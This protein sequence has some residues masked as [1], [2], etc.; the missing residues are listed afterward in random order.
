LISKL[1]WNVVGGLHYLKTEDQKPY[2]E[3][4]IGLENIGF[5]KLKFLRV[6]YVQSH[7]NG[8]QNNGILLGIDF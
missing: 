2:L 3:W 4:N 5:K 8:Q 1:N 7:H 6:D